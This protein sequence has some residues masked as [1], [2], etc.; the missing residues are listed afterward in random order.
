MRVLG[1]YKDKRFRSL[2][3]DYGATLVLNVSSAWTEAFSYK[4]DETKYYVKIRSGCYLFEILKEDNTYLSKAEADLLVKNIAYEEI[5]DL[6]ELNL[7][8]FSACDTTPY[9]VYVT[10]A[11]DDDSNTIPLE[12]TNI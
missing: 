7:G 9:E 2:S 3:M 12:V 6:D 5:V 10:N 4:E 8:L 11:T 1:H